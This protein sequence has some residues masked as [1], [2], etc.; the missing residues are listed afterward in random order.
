MIRLSHFAVVAVAAA[1]ALPALAQSQAKPVSA[2]MQTLAQ[3]IK[4]DK[5]L[6]VAA[7]MQLTDSEA[8]KFWPVYDAYQ[9]DLDAINKHMARVIRA[10]ADAYNKGS[11]ANDTARKLIDEA[12]AID[13]AELKLKRTYLPK[14]D[15]VLPGA[16]VARY[17]QIESKIR[18][19][20]RYEL[21]DGI[22]LVD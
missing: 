7:N 16:K 22:P 19:I 20:I 2:D 8:K 11:V 5:K 14:L 21:A 17:I 9:E 10:Y 13:A 1:L 15:K 3:K 6:V 12:V 18:A 4:A